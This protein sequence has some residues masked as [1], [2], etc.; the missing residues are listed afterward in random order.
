M[1]LLMYSCNGDGYNFQRNGTSYSLSASTLTPTNLSPAVAYQSGF[2]QWQDFWLD[3]APG[4]GYY[5]MRWRKNPNFC[6]NVPGSQANVRATFWT[7][8]YSQV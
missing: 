2:G 7:C 4:G 5:L 6:V 1:F 8:N 3:D